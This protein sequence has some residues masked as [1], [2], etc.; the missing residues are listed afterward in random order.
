M[1]RFYASIDN[2]HNGGI[3]LESEETRH[4]RDVLRLK[5][6]DRIQ[7]FDGLGN[8]YLCEIEGIVKKQTSLKIIEQISPVSKESDLDM[9]L[10]VSMLKGDKF[11]LVIQKAVELGVSNFVPLI[12]KRCDIKLRNA[13]KKVDRWRKIIIESSKQCGRAKLMEFIDPLEFSDFVKISAEQKQSDDQIFLFSERNGGKMPIDILPKKI[14]AI[15]G[16]EGGWEDS[17][18][19]FAKRNDVKIITFGGRILRAETAAISIPTILQNR[20]GDLN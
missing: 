11:D 10:A 20:F 16:S 18:L 12:T 9:T 17:E 5:F 2:F 6:G 3:T 7:I 8:E 4:L 15:I 19:K 1:R 14:T 13:D